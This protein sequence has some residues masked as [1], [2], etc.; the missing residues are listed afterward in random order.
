MAR[1]LS[2]VS[3]PVSLAHQPAPLSLLDDPEDDLSGTRIYSDVTGDFRYRS[4]DRCQLAARKPQLGCQL[5]RPLPRDND[6]YLRSDRHDKVASAKLAVFNELL[7]Y[8]EG[9]GSLA[10]RARPSDGY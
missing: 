4:C 5:A 3:G 8:G 2:A 6:I 7:G 1:S 10:D 9:N